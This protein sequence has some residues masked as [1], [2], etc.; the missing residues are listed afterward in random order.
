MNTRKTLAKRVLT[1]LA[2]A[3]VLVAVPALADR[4]F[5]G[6]GEPSGQI[7]G[8]PARPA[9]D[10]YPVR[11]VGIDGENIVPRE[12]F[13]LKPGKYTLTVTPI[14]TDPGGLTTRRPH[15]RQKEGMNKIDLVVEA[16]KTY[17]IGARYDNKNRRAPYST[18][19]YRIEE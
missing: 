6:A 5:A 4:P 11:F 7:V 18:V 16:G 8:S 2:A 14:I 12:V 15:P 9:G 19:V 17:Y 10:I 1:V 3:A 13:W